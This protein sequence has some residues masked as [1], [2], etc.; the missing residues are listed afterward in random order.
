[1]RIVKRLL[2]VLLLCLSSVAC[3]A[4]YP[5][6]TSWDFVRMFSKEVPTGQRDESNNSTW[7]YLWYDLN[8]NRPGDATLMQSFHHWEKVPGWQRD[9]KIEHLDRI[10]IDR[11]QAYSGKAGIQINWV[12]PVDGKVSA[13]IRADK[14]HGAGSALTLFSLY[15][16]DDQLSVK[17]GVRYSEIQEE[18]TVRRGD[19]LAFRLVTTGGW[20][21][22]NEFQFTVSLLSEDA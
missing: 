13:V 2:P 22:F 10:C 18:I 11:L 5:N 4:K 7:E 17:E 6:K 8:N 9:S 3:L 19:R 16:N 20:G 1:M 21:W 15:K 12:S 14:F